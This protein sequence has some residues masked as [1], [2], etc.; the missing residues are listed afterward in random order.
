MMRIVLLAAALL[1]AFLLGRRA[2]SVGQVPAER[3][4]EDAAGDYG[5][6]RV[7]LA[8]PALTVLRRN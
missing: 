5:Y 7:P 2:S 3:Q 6:I 4:P 8:T 1:G